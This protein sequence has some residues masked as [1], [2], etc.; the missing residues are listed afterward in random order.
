MTI[1]DLYLQYHIMP[2][3]QTHML[4][5]AGVGKIIL[6]GWKENI[7]TDLVMKSLLLHDMGNIVKFD[8][9][10]PLME[11]TDLDH[12]KQ[13]QQD[14]FEKYGRETHKVTTQIISEIGENEVNKVMEEEHAGYVAG[15]TMKIGNAS[16]PAKILAYC[17]VRVDPWGVV[18]MSKRI[19]DLHKRYGQDLS[20]YDFLY[21][22]EEEIKIMTRIDLNSI[23]EES[24]QPLFDELLTYTI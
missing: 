14:F 4:R 8:L 16:W 3:L 6:S 7:G 21:T 13:V 22:L 20:W 18:P 10:N 23:N 1:K 12:W 9:E 24:V 15:D 2:Q 19:E 17:D 5:V 11:M